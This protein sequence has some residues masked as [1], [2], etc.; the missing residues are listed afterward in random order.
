[1]KTDSLHFVLELQTNGKHEQNPF[2]LRIDTPLGIFETEIPVTEFAML[3]QNH[4][5]LL[6]AYVVGS[7]T[8]LKVGDHVAT[9][10]TVPKSYLGTVARLTRRGA[11][12]ESDD[13]DVDG[14][15]YEF[16]EL[17]SAKKPRSLRFI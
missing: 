4:P 7:N 17:V 15:E 12:I 11:V 6:E 9:N 13:P 16:S 1:M 14:N 5:V 8:R 10:A 2:T 3:M